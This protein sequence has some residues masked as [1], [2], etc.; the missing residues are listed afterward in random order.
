MTRTSRAISANGFASRLFR[1]RR[2]VT[3]P[4]RVA[5]E[6]VAAKALDGDDRTSVE[7]PERGVDIVEVP[8]LL[9]VERKPI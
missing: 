5:C 1:S 3:V 2:R 7:Q 8:R 4:L 6:V 9:A